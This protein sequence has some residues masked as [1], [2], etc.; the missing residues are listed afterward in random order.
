MT[1]RYLITGCSGGG[2]ST[3]LD[4]LAA[5]GYATVSEP[6]RRIVAEG[7]ALPWVDPAGFARRAVELSRADLAATRTSPTFFDRGL[8]DAAVALAHHGGPALDQTLGD[9]RH[10]D[11]AVFLAPPWPEIYQQDAGRRHDL[12]AATEEYTRL[13]HALDTLGYDA[14]PLPKAPVAERVAFV[15]AHL[16]QG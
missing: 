1:G 5:R 9:T 6:G 14:I 16:P 15:L 8:I 13:A 2:K 11:K 4:A 7:R 10:Y 12:S 3:L